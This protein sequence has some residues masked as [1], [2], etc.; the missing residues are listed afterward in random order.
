MQN[1]TQTVR[2]T[3]PVGYLVAERRPWTSNPHW[4]IGDDWSRYCET[5]A[6]A[7]EVAERWR[8]HGHGIP[9]DIG[10]LALVPVAGDAR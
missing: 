2:A 6:E 5:R 9:G 8:T 3:E 1:N 7:E 4:I 10:V